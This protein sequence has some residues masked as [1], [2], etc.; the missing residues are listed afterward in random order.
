[1]TGAIYPRRFSFE[2]R[3]ALRHIDPKRCSPGIPAAMIRRAFTMK[4]K[5]GAFDEYVGH[6]NTIGERWPQ[7]VD[8]INKSGIAQIT[9]FRDGLNLFLYSEIEDEE[10]WDRLW[11]S[12]VHREWAV[13]MEPLMHLDENGIV[14]AGELEEIFHFEPEPGESA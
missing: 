7:L 10:A 6:H 1:M 3:K 4:L 14:D 8:E 5:P 13:L 11:N 12:E 2:P 9:T